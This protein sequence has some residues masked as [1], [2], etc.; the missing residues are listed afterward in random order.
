MTLFPA[1][2]LG[3]S[4]SLDKS[5][6]ANGIVTGDPLPYTEPVMHLAA[7]APGGRVVVVGGTG[8][9]TFVARYMQADAKLDKSFAG[10]GHV[11]PMSGPVAIKDLLVLPDGRIALAGHITY[12][13]HEPFVNHQDALVLMLKPNGA[14]DSSWSGDGVFRYVN[15]DDA[16]VAGIHVAAGG[17]LA[18]DAA[19]RLVL[20]GERA[21]AHTSGST[22]E[23][24]MRLFAIRFT[25]A[26]NPDPD[27]GA[28]G[29]AV[30]RTSGTY[31]GDMTIA[32]DGGI[33]LAAMD[34]HPPEPVA[35][36]ALVARFTGAGVIDSSYGASGYASV[37]GEHWFPELVPQANGVVVVGRQKD[38]QG[39]TLD[40]PVVLS[41]LTPKGAPDGSFGSGGKTTLGEEAFFQGVVP[42]GDGRFVVVRAFP[43]TDRGWFNLIAANGRLDTTLE[44]NG[45]PNTEFFPFGGFLVAGSKVMFWRQVSAATGANDSRLRLTRHCFNHGCAAAPVDPDYAGPLGTEARVLANKKLVLSSPSRCVIPGGNF[46]ARLRVR[47]GPKRAREGSA[48]LRKI[49][50]VDFVAESTRRRDKG[51]PFAKKL[52]TDDLTPAV[53]SVTARVVARIFDTETEKTSRKSISIERRLTLCV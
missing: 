1:V 24:L 4:G 33:L 21:F 11:I 18:L 26:G 31:F 20:G 36:E 39:D 34:T 13:S 38:S 19:G 15:P 46:P 8:E 7:A 44:N 6:G 27:F 50:R 37:P 45:Y 43:G 49:L 23:S 28:D 29:V 48:R 35:G 10:A 51:A 17:A 32:P 52:P 2:A 53:T 30:G 42:R 9:D 12:P 22:T 5:Y 41:R 40:G 47:R 3:A 14:L 25:A 16:S